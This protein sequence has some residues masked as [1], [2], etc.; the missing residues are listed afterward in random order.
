MKI[1]A[2]YIIAEIG[3]NWRGDVQI[4]KKQIWEAK[5]CGADA[6][7]F[8][9]FTHKDLYGYDGN[10]VGG[11][12]EGHVEI[13]SEFCK[14]LNIDF[15]C[16]AFSADDYNFLNPYVKIHKIASCENE[17]P[18]ILEAVLNSDKFFLRSNGATNG[19]ERLSK[20]IPMECVAAYPAQPDAY[21]F[22]AY[23]LLMNWGLSD[24]TLSPD[25]ACIAVIKGCMFFEKHFDA[26]PDYG[27]TPDSPVSIDSEDFAY[28]CDTIRYLNHLNIVT[29][30]EKRIDAS[31]AGIVQYYKRRYVEELGG[32]FRT[33]PLDAGNK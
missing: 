16:S 21:S 24:H 5:H 13:F 22:R 28:Y 7:K 11:I 15:M 1:N 17:D 18:E 23:D 2:P 31:E 30:K 10:S 4:A 12:Q 29:E 8:Q 19:L 33:K 3:S 20:E 14:T 26:L 32:F 9:M 6:V 25:L 27:T